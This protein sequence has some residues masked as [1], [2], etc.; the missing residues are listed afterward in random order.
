V[1]LEDPGAPRDSVEVT[2]ANGEFTLGDRPRAPGPIEYR[3]RIRGGTAPEIAETIGVAVRR[4]AL[5]SIL[6][7]DASPSF[8]TVYLK[9]W[10][11]E[12]GAQ[13]TIRTS[14]SKGKYR[15]ERL[16]DAPG[17]VDRLTDQVLGRYEVLLA[18]GGSLAALSSPE[19]SALDRAIR[20]RGLGLLVTADV[21]WLLARGNCGLMNGVAL[22][23]IA[24]SLGSGTGD[25]GD[26]RVARPI[27]RDTPRRSRTGIEAEAASIR[28][29]GIE[30]LVTDEAGRMTAG[31]RKAGAGRIGLTLLR[32]PSRWVLEGEPDLF[33]GYWHAM[34]RAVSR[35][36]T[37]RA[38][39][40]A[41]GPLRADHPVWL[42]L[43]NSRTQPGAVIRAPGGESDTIPLAQDPF[44]PASW[45]GRYW[46]RTAGWHQ[47]DLVGGRSIPFRV[48]AESEWIGLEASARLAAT[49]PRVARQNGRMTTRDLARTW[50]GPLAFATL[51][52]ALSWLWIES[53]LGG[54]M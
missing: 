38:S 52:L 37:T 3:L 20:E 48:S 34:L 30:S 27:L 47:L 6:I 16:N 42:T 54:S 35:D 24:S 51:L 13:V 7:L 19:R 23:P 22:D 39:V 49:A 41:D 18:D 31:W 33:A 9:H 17:Q 26:R 45:S 28:P 25:Q 11:A 50:L 15:T 46:P 4:V 1:I 53:R 10:L 5:P 14:I 12:R 36:T 8:E 44:D 32:A 2:A 40:S 21:P 29:A 43:R